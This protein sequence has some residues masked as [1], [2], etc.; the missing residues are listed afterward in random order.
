VAGAGLEPGDLVLDLGA[1]RGALTAPL[2]AAG[3]RVI[4]IELHPG[5]AAFLRRRFAGA[6]ATITEADIT[7]IRLP[8]RPFRVVSNPPFTVMTHILRRLL[9]PA[10][11]LLSADLVVPAH[12]ACRWAAGRGAGASPLFAARVAARLG[13]DALRPAPPGDV[14]VLRLERRSS[15]GRA[16]PR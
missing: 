13:P 2:L 14:A 10:S 12:V 11:R 7:R 1:G 16:W 6:A 5:R 15:P 3:A 9:H 8:D 4:A